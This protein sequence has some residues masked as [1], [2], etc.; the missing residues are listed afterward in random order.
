MTGKE[1]AE[2]RARALLDVIKPIVT[3]L[4]DSAYKVLRELVLSIG[5]VPVDEPPSQGR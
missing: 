3:A 5:L 4:S 2:K 1:N